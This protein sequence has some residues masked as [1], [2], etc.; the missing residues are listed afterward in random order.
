[1]CVCALACGAGRPLRGAGPAPAGA[2]VPEGGY[3]LT[4]K[5]LTLLAP[6]AGAYE[7]EVGC[8]CVCVCCVCVCVRACTPATFA[9]A[10]RTLL[11][12]PTPHTRTHTRTHAHTHT[13]IVTSI[14]P[15]ENTDLEGL[16]KSSGNYCT[17]CEAE[18]F[19]GITYFPDRP[20][21]MSR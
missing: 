14:K 21:V 3:Q 18:G 4:V 8:C 16:Y 17:Q 19:R 13:Q 11:F 6:P 5:A 12:T 7:L 9:K 1:M 10:C 15:Q 20:D 2:E